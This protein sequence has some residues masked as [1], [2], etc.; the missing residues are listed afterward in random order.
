MQFPAINGGV[1]PVINMEGI[2]AGTLKLDGTVLA[3]IYLGKITKWND[4]AIVALNKDI[5]LPDADITVVH[6]SRW[7]G[8]QL[9]FHQLP[10]QGQRRLE[11]QCR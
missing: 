10:V 9:H 11:V 2:E 3:D 5:K 6:R 4:P 1:V 7:F 8:Y